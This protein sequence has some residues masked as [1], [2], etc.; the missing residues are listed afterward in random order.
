MHVSIYVSNIEA[1]KYRK[2]ILT[3]INGDI[4]SNIIIVGDFNTSLTKTDV[5]SR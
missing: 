2:Q 5:S 3:G 4:N 1:P